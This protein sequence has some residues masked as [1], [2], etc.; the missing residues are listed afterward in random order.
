[1]SLGKL[2]LVLILK[3]L[4]CF[5][6]FKLDLFEVQLK[7]TT[8]FK[9]C[10]FILQKKKKN[11]RREMYLLP[12]LT[13]LYLIQCLC[14]KENS[15]WW[16][17]KSFQFIPFHGP[18]FYFNIKLNKKHLNSLWAYA[19][20]ILCLQFVKMIPLS[21]TCFVYFMYCLTHSHA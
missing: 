3:L 10:H 19:T 13:W 14:F 1:M 18:F 5:V 12:K 2:K 16:M 8:G 11:V 4:I 9:V 17:I 15:Y 20:Y 21:S 7:R 6:R